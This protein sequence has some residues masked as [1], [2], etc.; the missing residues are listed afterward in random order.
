MDELT[1]FQEIDPK[2]DL[3]MY[4]L[5]LYKNILNKKEEVLT[6]EL[7]TQLLSDSFTSETI[8]MED[9]WLEIIRSPERD[10]AYRK[11]NNANDLGFFSKPGN[12]GWE[13]MEFTL[14]VLRFQIAELHKMEGKQL[15]NQMKEYGVASETGTP[16]YNFDPISNLSSGIKKLST[17][18]DKP[19]TADW[20]VIGTILQLGRMNLLTSQK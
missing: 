15:D 7:L 6:Q 8:E 9:S 12:Y 17:S 13:D 4:L 14:Q 5:S 10:K 16:W 1:T 2:P 20:S 18:V 19:T 3:K 11:K